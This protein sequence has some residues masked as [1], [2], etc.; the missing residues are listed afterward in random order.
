MRKSKQVRIDPNFEDY[1]RSIA[2]NRYIKGLD[3][4]ELKLPRL[5]K[6]ITNVPNLKKILEEARIDD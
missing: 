2:K 1:L 5:T 4:R 6:A 3:K